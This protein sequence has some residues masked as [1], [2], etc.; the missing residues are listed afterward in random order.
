MVSAIVV[1]D[2]IDIVE[3]FCDYLEIKNINVVGRGHNGKDAVELYQKHKP[4]VV[5][6]DMMMPVYDGLYALENIRKINSQAKIVV[7]TADL[8][9]ETALRLNELKPTKVFVKP[10]DLEKISKAVTSII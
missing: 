9:E 10:C 5:F 3:V 8:R 1:D 6:L 4:D 7:I 2:D